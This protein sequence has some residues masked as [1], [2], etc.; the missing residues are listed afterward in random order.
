M[1]LYE[2]LSRLC[3]TWDGAGVNVPRPR[4]SSAPNRFPEQGM[5]DG[6]GPQVGSLKTVPK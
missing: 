5:A 2:T 4:H 3:L 1:T 6:A